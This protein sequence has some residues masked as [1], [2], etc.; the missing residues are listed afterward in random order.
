MR[1]FIGGLALG[2]ILVLPICNALRRSLPWYWFVFVGGI[3]AW[4][5]LP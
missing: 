1:Q 4:G 3:A 5:L 2:H